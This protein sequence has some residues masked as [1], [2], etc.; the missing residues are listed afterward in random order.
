MRLMSLSLVALLLAGCSGSYRQ[1]HATDGDSLR[2]RVDYV[3]T[4][5]AADHA[6]YVGA[7]AEA[8][9]TY[10]ALHPGR[11]RPV[12]DGV[13]AYQLVLGMNL[14][15]IGLVYAGRAAVVARVEASI[16]VPGQ[17]QGVT[18]TV[19]ADGSTLLVNNGGL[20]MWEGNGRGGPR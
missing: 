14:E 17:M 18:E 15:E 3:V 4:Q 6:R 16:G 1:I 7:C 5:N 8:C 11:P 9:T 13:L 10:V 12:L 20:A 19:D 2:A